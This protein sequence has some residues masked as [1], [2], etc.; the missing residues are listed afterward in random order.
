[1]FFSP[2]G[3]FKFGH[4]VFD[5]NHVCNTTFVLLSIWQWTFGLLGNFYLLTV[6]NMGVQISWWESSFSS[7]VYIEI[8]LWADTVIFSLLSWGTAVLFFMVAGLFYIPTNSAPGLQFLH[9]LINTYC[10]YFY[11]DCS[12]LG[13]LRWYFIICLFGC[14]RSQLRHVGSPLPNAGSFTV[15]RGL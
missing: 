8:E 11:F 12:Y 6:M 9:I 2:Q 13:G 3:I 7:F 4:F 14:C 5:T 15:T 1:M 10:F